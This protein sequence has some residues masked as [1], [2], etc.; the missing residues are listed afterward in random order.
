MAKY[1]LR[2]E[3][4]K[5]RQSGES[6]KVIAQ[7]LK[8]SKSSISRWVRDIELTIE[9]R[10]KLREKE[11][12]GG[13]RGRIKSLKILKEKRQNMLDEFKKLGKSMIPSLSNQEFLA[14]GLALYWGEGGKSNRR[15]EFCNSDPKIILF[16]IKWF[17]ECFDVRDEDFRVVVGINEVH[18][19]REEKVKR[20]WSDLTQIPLDQFR[21]TSFKKSINKKVYDNF[22][23]HFGTLSILIAKSS[24]LYYQ[25]MS[26]IEALYS[27]KITEQAV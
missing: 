2:N 22:E 23:S 25:I 9:Q 26:L 16:I 17:K 8:V 6:V 24:N 15:A 20:Y 27:S 10:N 3:A 13:E 11:L 14:S 19:K 21:K 7:N 12:S 5:L 18:S 4:R 1:E